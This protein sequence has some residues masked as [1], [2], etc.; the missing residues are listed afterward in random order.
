MGLEFQRSG[1]TR[2]ATPWARIKG[3]LLARHAFH[4][5]YAN[6][7]RPTMDSLGER[8][9]LPTS[10]CRRWPNS[11]SSSSPRLAI[12]SPNLTRLT[13]LNSKEASNITYTPF[14]WTI[15]V[16]DK[17]ESL[18]REL[19]RQNKLLMVCFLSSNVSFNR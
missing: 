16:R 12:S 7:F 10:L 2:A 14:P 1:M 17:L 15:A 18:C 13:Y 19:Q 3:A 5:Q 9:Q 6:W 4:A 11:S 8:L